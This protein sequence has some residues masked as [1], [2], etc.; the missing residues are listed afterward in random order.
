MT[1]LIEVTGQDVNRYLLSTHTD[2]Q[3]GRQCD[4][5]SVIVSTDL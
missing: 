2:W 5:Q 4:H 1:S 3:T